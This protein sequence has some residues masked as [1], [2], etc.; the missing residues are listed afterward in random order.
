MAVD[1]IT[2]EIIKLGVDLVAKLILA[3]K[4]DDAEAVKAILTRA[5]VNFG[6][7]EEWSKRP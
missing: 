5:G 1:P 6:D 3:G 2:L 7:V 4:K